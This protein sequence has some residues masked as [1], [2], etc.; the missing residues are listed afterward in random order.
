LLKTFSGKAAEGLENMVYNFKEFFNLNKKT[1]ITTK[2]EAANMISNIV[3]PTEEGDSPEFL[4]EVDGLKAKIGLQ[5]EYVKNQ[6]K[7]SE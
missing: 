6:E 5:L 3:G 4:A 1:Y 2:T 7:M